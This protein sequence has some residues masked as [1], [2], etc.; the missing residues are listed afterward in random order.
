MMASFDNPS[1]TDRPRPSYGGLLL[2]GVT[3][4]MVIACIFS[5]FASQRL[6]SL[7]SRHPLT[8][9]PTVPL[10]VLPS[11]DLARSSLSDVA[12]VSRDDGWIVGENSGYALILRYQAGRWLPQP[13]TVAHSWLQAVAFAD[14]QRGWAVGYHVMD[15][16]PPTASPSVGTLSTEAL[17]LHYQKGHWSRVMPS[18]AITGTLTKI[19]LVSADD[20]WA[21]NY[22]GEGGALNLIHYN[23]GA[24]SLLPLPREVTDAHGLAVAGP[25]DIWIG[26]AGGIMHMYGAALAQSIQEIKV[27][28]LALDLHEPRNGWAAGLTFCGAATSTSPVCEQRVALYHYDGATWAPAATD[29][30]GELD[31]VV[32]TSGDD[33]WAAG[34]TMSK[35][36]SGSLILHYQNGE[37]RSYATTFPVDITALSMTNSSEGWAIGY[38]RLAHATGNAPGLLHCRNGVWTQISLT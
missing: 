3:L 2:L 11:L 28:L 25:N 7:L 15:G 9:T 20:W 16:P 38:A 26:I 35:T 24:W 33:V 27:N 19:R 1:P 22:Q 32:M 30:H 8:P 37:W 21:L 5:L 13:A 31:A 34:S 17:V 6:Q 4:V 36:Q 12:M 14:T 10:A 23:Q 29:A 18:I